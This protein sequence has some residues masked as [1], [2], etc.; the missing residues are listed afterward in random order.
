M[1]IYS[2]KGRT[3]GTGKLKVKIDEVSNYGGEC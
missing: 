1:D 3:V 2:P